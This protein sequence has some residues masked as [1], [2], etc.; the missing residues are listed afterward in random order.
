[1]VGEIRDLET[2][3]IAINAALTGHLVFSTLHTND[4][5]GA[6]TRMGMM[7]IEPF[8]MSSALLM[9]VAQRLTRGICKECRENYEV[10]ASWLKALGVSDKLMKI[11]KGKVALAR[12]KG[13]DSCAKTGYRGRVGLY[14]VLEVTD[15]IRSLILEKAPANKVKEMGRQQGMLTLRDCAIRKVLA[16]V[17]TVEEMIR[18]TAADSD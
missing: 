18:L 15:E 7:G 13:C 12:G 3:L 1:M 10:E 6:I 8:L 2:I 17:T 9:V 4:S 11:E 14:E 5:A 16:G